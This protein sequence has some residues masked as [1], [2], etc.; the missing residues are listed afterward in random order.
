MTEQVASN[1][2]NRTMAIVAV[3]VVAVLLLDIGGVRTSLMSLIPAMPDQQAPAVVVTT[4]PVITTG[5]G[6]AGTITTG[7]G[8]AGIIT[9]GMPGDSTSTTSIT[10]PA[11][12]YSGPNFTGTATP[13]TVGRNIKVASI[14]PPCDGNFGSLDC[15][16]F[17]YGSLKA[18]PTVTLNFNRR[19]G[20]SNYN[21]LLDPANIGNIDTLTADYLE[22]YVD[23]NAYRSSASMASTAALPY[24]YWTDPLYLRVTNKSVI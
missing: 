15:W 6:G 11:I 9:T 1:K 10:A 23:D 17:D 4:N 8:G 22:S 16:K 21:M 13:L 14:G 2:S 24:V 18:D 19:S 7:T 20:G 12:L 3:A 5:A